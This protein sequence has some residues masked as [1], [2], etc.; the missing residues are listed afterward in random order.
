MP[1]KGGKRK[2][3]HTHVVPP[4]EGTPGAEEDKVPRSFVFKLGKVAKQV[5]ELVEEMRGVMEPNTARKLRERS[6]NSLKD[7]AVVSKPFGVTHLM[8]FGQTERSLTYRI[9]R[10]PDGPTLTF[11]VNQYCLRRH[12]RALQR[13]PVETT[14]AF[15]TAPLVVLNN[16]GDASAPQEL[17]LMKVTLQNMFPTINVAEVKLADCRRIVLFNYDKATKS[18]EM[19]HY[20]IR[21]MPTGINKAI[22]KVVQAKVPNLHNLDDIAEYV[23]GGGGAA[24]DSEVDDEE[25]K[26]VLPDRY[27]GRGNVKA[28]R[29]SIRLHEL[30]PRVSMSLYKVERGLASGDV[31]YHSYITKTAEEVVALKNKFKEQDTLK[32]KRREEQEANVAR[33][34]AALE[35]KKALKAEKRAAK[36][37]ANGGEVGSADGDDD[38]DEVEDD[39]E[40]AMDE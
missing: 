31:L 20:A 27:G 8:A 5:N 39:V 32:R 18:V 10:A 11:K 1:R 22:K 7:F 9:A 24:S 21:A 25:S 26:V 36:L 37:A 13:R 29:S 14:Q 17:K 30:G 33:K 4:P 23:Q 6:S 19:R 3:T 28:Q 34:K 2:K 12:V 15:K 40:D 16:F 35:E 38:D